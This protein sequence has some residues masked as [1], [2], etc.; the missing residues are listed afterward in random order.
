MNAALKNAARGLFSRLGYQVSRIAPEAPTNDRMR[1]G[2]LRDHE[3]VRPYATYAPWKT[4][5]A[6]QSALDTIKGHTLVDFYRCWELWTLVEQSAK[7][8]GDILEVG[9][10]RGGTGALI[11]K[12]AEL[13]GIEGTVYL[14]DTFSGVVKVGDHDTTYKGGEHADTSRE[15]V[16]RLAR[17]VMKLTN[18]KILEGIFPDD[19]GGYLEGQGARFRLCHIDVDVYQSAKDIVDWIWGRMPIGGITIYDDYGSF[20][21]RGITEFVNA[22]A[23]MHDRIVL[24][25]LNGHA[26]VIKTKE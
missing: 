9:V 18:V 25:N 21:C 26:V 7:L 22:Q 24:H 13:C 23:G 4:D 11:A 2:E 12:K 8:E 5:A 3:E 15:I 19:S 1:A 16:E 10:W 17:D 20:R 14:C 6:F